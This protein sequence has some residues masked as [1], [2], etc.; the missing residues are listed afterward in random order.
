MADIVIFGGGQIAEV[1]KAYIDRHG[2]HRIVGYTVDAAYVTT[3][4]FL[5]LPLVPWERLEQFFPPGEIQLLGPLSYRRMNE[6]RR[7]RYFEGKARNYQFAS[8]VHPH[9]HIYTEDIGENCFIL[10][11]NVIQPFV[12]IGNN[13]MMWS[14]NHI[15]HHSII[16]DHCFLASQVGIAGSTRIGEG[17]FLAGQV[18]VTEGLTIG[19]NCLLSVGTLVT[20]DLADG[21]VVVRGA[22]DHVAN[23]PSSRIRARI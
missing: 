11:A 22:A 20:K 14:G 7:D 5:G 10:E 3:D 8:F 21:S 9:S 13:V 1:A 17:C 12:R 23:F 15:G 6:F 2:D 18:G 16:G 4:R 19:N